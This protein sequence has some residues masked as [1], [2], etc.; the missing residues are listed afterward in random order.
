MLRQ[1]YIM[2]SFLIASASILYIKL[3][4]LVG[5][6]RLNCDDCRDGIMGNVLMC[7]SNVNKYIYHNILHNLF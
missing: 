1:S 2:F 7:I 3:I 5:C 6:H 4:I